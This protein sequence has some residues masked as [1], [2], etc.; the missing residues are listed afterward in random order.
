MKSQVEFRRGDDCVFMIS[1]KT[2][3]NY[4]NDSCIHKISCRYI[5]QGII[6]DINPRTITSLTLPALSFG[7]EDWIL[8]QYKANI[9]LY[10]AEVNR[11]VYEKQVERIVKKRQ[12]YNYWMANGNVFDSQV[13][14][15]LNLIWLDLC[16]YFTEDTLSGIEKLLSNNN[17]DN[18]GVFAITLM[19]CRQSCKAKNFYSKL[20]KRYLNTYFTTIQN[21]TSVQ[22]PRILAQIL[23]ERTGKDVEIASNYS[24]SPTSSNGTGKMSMYAFKWRSKFTH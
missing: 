11:S 16:G 21:F 12:C 19:S 2:E 23:K 3:F 22:L 5:I 10:T 8:K 18:E 14:K 24:Y 6:Q 20:Q 7:L 9:R 1:Q 17:L 4:K 15:K 13:A